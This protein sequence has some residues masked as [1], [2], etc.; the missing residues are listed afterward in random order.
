MSVHY[1]SA[2]LCN[3]II[4][5]FMLINNS[6]TLILVTYLSYKLLTFIYKSLIFIVS[7]YLGFQHA[8]TI[9]KLILQLVVGIV[10]SL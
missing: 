4:H 1:E 9:S 5:Y 3:I 8:P 6:K 2:N 7:A 10:W